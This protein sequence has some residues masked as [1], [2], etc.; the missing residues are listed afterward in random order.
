MVPGK[1]QLHFT[2]YYIYTGPFSKAVFGQISPNKAK[3]S[4]ACT[5]KL[6]YQPGINKKQGV[7]KQ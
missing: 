2:S 3:M 6:N 1:F 5:V 7:L 4:L